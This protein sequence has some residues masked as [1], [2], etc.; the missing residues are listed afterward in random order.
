MSSQDKH[1][2]VY[3][4]S[5][6]FLAKPAAHEGSLRNICGNEAMMIAVRRNTLT[7][8]RHDAYANK[9]RKP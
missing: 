4:R 9:Q 7:I 1:S 8:A 2:N 6:S 5:S 3:L